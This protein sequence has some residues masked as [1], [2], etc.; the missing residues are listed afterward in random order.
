MITPTKE[1]KFEKE[2]EQK[3]KYS[4][5][6]KEFSDFINVKIKSTGQIPYNE[7]EKKYYLTDFKD[8]RYLSICLN[9]SE[10]FIILEPQLKNTNDIKIEEKEDENK[11]KLIIPLSNPL[12]KELLMILPK[13]EKNIESEI[14]EL[15]KIINKQQETINQLNER[16]SIL[17]KE[18][19]ER[20]NKE[21]EEREKKERE[22]IEYFMCKNSKII[23]NDREKD[24]AIRKWINPNK[25][26][27]EIK[28]LF[29][30]SR[31]GNQSSTYHRLCDNK[32]N[33]LT[34]IETDNNIKFGGFA[35]KSW[36]IP[37][38]FI[39]NAFM[40]SLNKMKKYERLNN[41]KAMYNGSSYGPVFG[42]QWDI[43]VN[44]TMTSGGEQLGSNSVF[45]NKYEI[46]N[47]GKFNIKEM[48]IFQIE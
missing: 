33:L 8:N 37:D 20:E 41:N 25:K 48:E 21:R 28:L 32:N 12:V 1:I 3:K 36:G 5:E 4:I 42:N 16:L 38:Q 44:S 23:L 17:E 43:F 2:S 29:R 27:F 39:E 35:S 15:Y 40:F 18:R 24:L 7:Y 13:I 19:E 26:N 22:E 47:N 34:L 6:I 45:F 30:M 14:K 31:D 10:I 11:I 9:I 46:T